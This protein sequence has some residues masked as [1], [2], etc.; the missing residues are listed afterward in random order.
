ME[1]QLQ[2]ALVFSDRA[3]GRSAMGAAPSKAAV[4]RDC[5]Y[6]IIEEIEWAKRQFGRPTLVDDKVCIGS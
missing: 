5:L 1:G 2:M 6:Q 4:I 3:V